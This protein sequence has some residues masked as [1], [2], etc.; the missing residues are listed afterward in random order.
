MQSYLLIGVSY[1]KQNLLPSK[2]PLACKSRFHGA[3]AD[4][5]NPL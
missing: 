3:F 5:E 1:L 4:K 2:C